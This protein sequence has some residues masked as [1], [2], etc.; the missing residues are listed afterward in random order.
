M[1]G[2]RKFD[3][4]SD[5]VNRNPVLNVRQLAYYHNVTAMHNTITTGQPASLA[6]SLIQ[7]I[8]AT[9]RV[10]RQSNDIRLP[11]IRQ[12]SGKR[13]FVYRAAADYNLLPPPVRALSRTCFAAA[14]DAMFGD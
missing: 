9:D 4:I 12:N 8:D 10:T 11:P 2:R 7:N 13:Q 1:T 6:R 5:V 3:H 14:V